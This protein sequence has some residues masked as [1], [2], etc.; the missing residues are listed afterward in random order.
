MRYFEGCTTIEEVKERFRMHAKVLHPDA[1]GNAADFR[2]MMEEYQRAFERYKNIHKTM[3]GRTYQKETTETAEE[4]ADIISKVIH[5]EG[6]KIEII[7][8]WV[9]LT[10]NT[11]IYKDEIKAAGFFWSKSKTAWYYTGEKERPRKRGHYT[12]DGLRQKWGTTEV[13]N[14]AHRKLA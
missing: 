11:K 4:F 5:M 12:M 13:E 8:T 6:V 14:E 10:G 2:D 9:W 7:G 3:D 1:G